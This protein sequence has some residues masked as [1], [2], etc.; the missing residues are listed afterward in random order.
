LRA[1]P[2][3]LLAL[4]H[5]GGAES[6][7]EVFGQFVKLGI[8]V[9]LDGLLGGV[10]NHVTVMAPGKMILQLDFG[11]IVENAFQVVGQLVQKLRA[12]HRLPSPLS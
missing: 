12:F 2:L 6:A 7:T 1:S 8:T 11:L 4:G 9:Y 5:D 10:A 3:L